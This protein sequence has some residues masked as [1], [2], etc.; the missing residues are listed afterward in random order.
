M[1]STL[2]KDLLSIIS[3]LHWITAISLLLSFSSNTVAD[4]FKFKGFYWNMTW[5][6]TK[7]RAESVYG[8]KCAERAA[9]FGADCKDAH[10]GK[11]LIRHFDTASNAKPLL[12][13]CDF[14]SGCGKT[15]EE[16]RDSIID[17]Y[18]AGVFETEFQRS[19]IDSTWICADLIDN[20]RVCLREN[21]KGIHSYIQFAQQIKKQPS[22]PLN[23]D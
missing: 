2:Q 13:F 18:G 12:F 15:T 9:K 23:L 19:A 17:H 5:H 16:V 8:L 11:T 22:T 7:E 3:K 1:I 14:Y 6:E 21:E 4:E 10:T 20:S